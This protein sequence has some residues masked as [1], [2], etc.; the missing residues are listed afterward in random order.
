MEFKLKHFN[1]LST[2]ELYEILKSRAEVFVVE[3][4]CPYQDIDDKDRH[5]H[6]LFFE[7]N[8]RVVS[9][10][11]V[12][13]KGI[14]YDEVSIG[15]V[16]TLKSYRGQGLSKK[17]LLEAIKFTE[18]ILNEVAIRISA[19]AYLIDFYTSVGFKQISDTYLEDGIPHV[20]MIYNT[21]KEEV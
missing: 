2:N 12:I 6:H 15:R 7:E 17:I 1:D 13:D 3:Q 5:S 10:V 11:R 19:Q 16:I 14:S 9:Y 21:K 18:N 20:A 8:N 4:N